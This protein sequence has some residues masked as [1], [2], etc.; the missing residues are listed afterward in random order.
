MNTNTYTNHQEAIPQGLNAL[1]VRHS[2]W[3]LRT[4]LASVFLFHG[5]QKF[6]MGI[7]GFAAMMELP[8][9]IAFLVALAEVLAGLGIIAGAAWHNRWGDIATRLAALAIVPV[10]L[11]AITMVHWGQWSFMASESHPMGGI[12]FQVVLLFLALYFFLRGNQ[13]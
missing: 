11:G 9:A 10:M 8:I 6:F 2:H 1:L 12:E 5:L 7:G 13:S 3:L 4:A